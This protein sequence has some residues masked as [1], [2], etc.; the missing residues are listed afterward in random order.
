MN[1]AVELAR[2]LDPKK[3]QSIT[4]ELNSK[5]IEEVNKL[6]ATGF[7]GNTPRQTVL[8]IFDAALRNIALLK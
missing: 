7:W 6:Y 1:T 8:R 3:S 5:Q 4:M 2:P